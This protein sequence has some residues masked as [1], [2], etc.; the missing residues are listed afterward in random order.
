MRFGRTPFGRRK[1]KHQADFVLGILDAAEVDPASFESFPFDPKKGSRGPGSSPFGHGQCDKIA[2]GDLGRRG[3]GE[4]CG[5]RMWGVGGRK[6]RG[7][8]EGRDYFK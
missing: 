2:D 1:A 7:R 4:G 8:L 6:G 3:G 5:H